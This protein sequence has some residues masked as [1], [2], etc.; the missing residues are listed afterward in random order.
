MIFQNRANS[1]EEEQI[2]DSM[3]LHDNE[4]PKQFYFEVLGRKY[5]LGKLGIKGLILDSKIS[6]KREK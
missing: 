2:S 6:L 1:F 5:A 3:V 4:G